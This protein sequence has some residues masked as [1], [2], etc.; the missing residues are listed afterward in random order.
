MKACNS[1]VH[2]LYIMHTNNIYELL[3]RMYNALTH[4]LH[5]VIITCQGCKMTVTMFATTFATVMD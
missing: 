2:V 3:I 4:V 1:T 5:N